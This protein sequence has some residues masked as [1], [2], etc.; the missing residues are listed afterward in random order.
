M[1]K[2]IVRPIPEDN[3]NILKSHYKC[4]QW[5]NIRES[6]S[7]H[8]FHTELLAT[9]NKIIPEK[10]RNISSYD[11]PWFMERLKRL[12]KKNKLEYHKNRK[13]E[14]WMKLHNKYKKGIEHAKHSFY[15]KNIKKLRHTKPHQ[16]YSTLKYLS[17]FDQI[18]TVDPIVEDIKHLSDEDQTGHIVE[19]LE[20]CLMH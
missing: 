5:H 13:S 2:I 11:Q 9:C 20:I 4:K 12:N 15:D 3:L 1:R 10:T 6:N 16:W 14:R 8:Y 17:N 18:K 7:A 19:R